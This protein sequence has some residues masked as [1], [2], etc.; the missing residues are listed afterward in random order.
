MIEKIQE[1]MNAS[2]AKAKQAVLE[3]YRDD[4]DFREFL[5]YA[6]NPRLSYH[7]SENTLLTQPH[8]WVPTN[9]SYAPSWLFAWCLRLSQCGGVDRETVDSSAKIRLS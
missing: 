5:Y 9:E 7:L 3:K 8:W 2:G 1:L 4:E 6:L